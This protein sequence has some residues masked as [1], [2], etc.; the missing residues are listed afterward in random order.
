MDPNTIDPG[1]A[2]MSDGIGIFYAIGDLFDLGGPVVIILAALSVISVAIMLAKLWQFR[3]GRLNR[4]G[5]A[6][7]AAQLWSAGNK[8][9]ALRVAESDSAPAAQAVAH[10]MRGLLRVK[11]ETELVR[12]DV[13]RV[14]AKLLRKAGSGLRALEAITQVAP[15]L[16]LFGTVIGMIEA[17]QALH[18]AG[19]SVDPAL[20]AG[21]IWVALLTTAVG[22]AVAIPASL[23]N[24][25]FESR[26]DEAAAEME[27]LITGILT[28]NV[29]AATP[30]RGARPGAADHALAR[31]AANAD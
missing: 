17:F 10:V 23:A 20:L 9:E 16:G 12:E 29:T 26:V 14:C 13:E 11:G 27:D 5:P 6:R 28:G 7:H 1:D 19:A 22:L 8:A 4:H 21:G 3:F 30:E 31:G 18:N 2:A 15:L 25:W 24:S